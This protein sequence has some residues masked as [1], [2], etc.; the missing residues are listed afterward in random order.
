MRK[1]L[2]LLSLLLTVALGYFGYKNLHKIYPF[3]SQLTKERVSLNRDLQPKDQKDAN[4]VGSH[5]C[6]ECHEENY[7]LWSRSRHPKMI[8]DIKKDP[9]VVVADF[10]RLPDD[11]DFTLKDAVYTIGGKFKQRYMIRK[12]FNNTK[13]FILGNYQWNVQTKKW[14]KFKPW[15]Y[16][17]KEAYPHDNR[18]LPTSKVCDGCHFTGFMS[19]EVRVESGIGCE[20]CHGP[21]SNHI[22]NP[23][24]KLYKASTSDPVRQNEVCLQCHLRNRDNRLKELN[25]TQIYADARDYPLGYEAGRA[26]SRYKLSAPFKMGKETKEFYANG[27][28]KKNRTQGNEF[29]RSIKAKHGITCINCHNPHSLTP[30]AEK[31]S[32]NK[33]CMKCH[34][35]GSLI[36][37]HQKDLSSH[38]H[39]KPNSKGSLCVECHMPKTG[40]HTGK[41][42]ITVRSHLFGFTTPKETELYGMPPKT[43]ACYACHEDRGLDQLQK[44][45]QEWGILS[46]DKR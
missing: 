22:K 31:N 24:S 16:W 8:Q 15:K 25:I 7:D 3:Y 17:Y 2:I 42:P 14:Q 1:F 33:L 5:K 38:T 36:G 35:F 11:A 9:S 32:G 12:D 10:S 27:A 23:A 21:G 26:L 45:L 34:S 4:F 19:R 6:K 46:W 37:P 44:D 41:S 13:D 28:A 40:R 43:N 39:H 18:E 20:S 30:T 29:V